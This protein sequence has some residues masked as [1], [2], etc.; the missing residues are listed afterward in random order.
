MSSDSDSSDDGRKKK[1]KGRKM[2]SDDS[3]SDH[4]TKRRGKAPISKNFVDSD[5]E[6]SEDED[7]KPSPSRKRK[8]PSNKGSAKKRGRGR[9]DSSDEELNTVNGVSLTEE[10]KTKMQGMSE[11]DREIYLYNR[12]EEEET[13]KI[14]DQIAKRLLQKT[15]PAPEEKERGRGRKKERKVESDDSD[16]SM[17]SERDTKKD[18]KPVRKS[19]PTGSDSEENVRVMPS[20]AHRKK[21][22]KSAMEDLMNKRKEKEAKK[23]SLAVDAVF[24]TEKD[25]S[26][27][28]SS[29]SASS[30]SS[31]PSSRS[32]SPTRSRSASPSKEDKAGKRPVECLEELVLARLSRFKLAKFVHASFFNKTVTDCYVKIEVG[33]NNYKIAQITDVVETAKVYKV[34]NTLTNRG[35]KLRMGTV[36]QVYRL[37]YISNKEFTQQD[38]Q[39][40][41]DSMKHHNRSIPTMAEIQKK[42]KDI[43]NAINH[44]YSNS[45]VDAMI[46]EKARFKPTPKNFAMT[47]GE[48]MKKLEYSKQNGLHEEVQRLQAE[49]DNVDNAADVL[50]KKRAGGITAI[51]WINKRNRNMMKEQFLGEKKVE[52]FS[53]REDDPFTRKSGKMR[54]VS[55]SAKNLAAMDEDPT[56]GGVSASSSTTSNVSSTPLAVKSTPSTSKGG[57]DLFSLHSVKIDLDL[58]LNS[59][60][61]PVND[62]V[63]SRTIHPT[64][65]PSS[66]GRPLSLEDYKKRKMEAKAS[67]A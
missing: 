11:K 57:N 47:K 31:S 67:Q 22:Q 35:L 8:A 43:A 52:G 59:L 44:E 50:D 41:L 19:Q 37:E 6:R 2:S 1:G 36:D 15:N 32:S 53:N 39:G 62:D 34:E 27:D 5:S 45:E 16:A 20:E 29:S 30:R 28:S 23:A 17:D 24:G 42:Q 13:K 54:V 56:A 26:S 66:R 58:D 61:T 51:D 7:T 60:R 4:K 48:L 55:G 10:D 14:R 49:I 64:S 9:G 63:S 33:K 65:T 40:W 3:D 18:T 25:S 12:M 21:K 38:F 46:K